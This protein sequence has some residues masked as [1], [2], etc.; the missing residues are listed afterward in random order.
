MH[1]QLTFSYGYE[2][3]YNPET[4]SERIKRG[5]TDSISDYDLAY[6]LFR[7]RA[8]EA[9]TALQGMAAGNNGE[10]LPKSNA[11][12]LAAVELLRRI[13]SNRRCANPADIYR[14]V[15]YFAY[16]D[17]QEHF[18]V[19]M[20]DGAH[21]IIKPVEV[22]K[23]LLNR[24]LCAPREVFAPCIESRACACVL[25]HNHPSENLEPSSDD[26]ECTLRLKR[27]GELLGIQVLDHIIIGRTGYRSMLES[28]EFL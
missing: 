2:E 17:M 24:T 21:Q 8:C 3:T 23:G 20:L 19:V 6:M 12:A 14:A 9:M 7:D 4:L 11:T 15:A 18:V 28:G 27:A 5:E 1:E 26:L 25:V 10:T 22:S 16:Q 13:Y